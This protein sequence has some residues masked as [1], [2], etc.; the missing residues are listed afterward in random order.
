M[1]Y[2]PFAR[3]EEKELAKRGSFFTSRRSFIG[4]L[5]YFPNLATMMIAVAGSSPPFFSSS[6]K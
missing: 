5:F 3:L 1:T 6:S 4:G 2:I